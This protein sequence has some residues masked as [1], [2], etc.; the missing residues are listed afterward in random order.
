MASGITSSR[1]VAPTTDNLNASKAPTE[2]LDG[3]LF[4][5]ANDK[6]ERNENYQF[7][8]FCKY[9]KAFRTST[10]PAPTHFRYLHSHSVQ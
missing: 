4:M 8:W 5:T 7:L 10:L 9:F 2:Y 1:A 3:T 6:D